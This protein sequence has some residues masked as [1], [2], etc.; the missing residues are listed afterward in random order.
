MPMLESSRFGISCS[1]NTGIFYFGSSL[2][3][4]GKLDEVQ[5]IVEATKYFPRTR[6]IMQL[7]QPS[8]SKRNKAGSD[9][10]QDDLCVEQS[11]DAYL[12]PAV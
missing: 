10:V 1:E 5:L 6:L 9:V 3:Q 12:L 2:S 4:I 11:V 7:C 8:C